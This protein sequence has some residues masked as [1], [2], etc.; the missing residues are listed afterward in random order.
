M[1]SKAAA[2][3]SATH[4]ASSSAPGEIEVDRNVIRP[5]VSVVVVTYR[6]STEIPGCVDSLLKQP[7][8]VEVF[9]VDNASPD[10][11]PEIIADY[12]SRFDNV[13]AIL[14]KENLGLAAAN[15][16]ALGRCQGDYVLILNPD[17]LV[18]D[19]T[20]QRMVN[21]LDQ[22]L[23]VGIVGPQNLYSDGT[24]H[25]SFHRRWGLLQV[26]IWR[27][28]PYRFA[29]S[30]FDVFSSYRSQDL[31]FVS[32]A[33]LLIRQ[34][35]FERIRGYDAEFFLTVEDACDLCIRARQTGSRV[36]FLPEAEVIHFGGRSGVQAPYIV[37][38]EGYRG[39][40]YYFLKHKGIAQ[41]VLV[42]LL[43]VVGAGVRSLLA[44]ILG[45]ARR[46]Y[47]RVG[48]IYGRVCWDLV[49]QNPI[50]VSKLRAGN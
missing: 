14:N 33:C 44:G 5:R 15:N 3:I 32:G 47:R 25:R 50:F 21:F 40:V 26:L 2:K 48:R 46:R 42:S 18:R 39:T 28:L 4:G 29:R 16:C 27:L 6:S 17:T 11:S 8:P 36:V 35:I 45:V 24:R 20:L 41:A 22:N 30:F 34:S 1:Q 12:A 43:L 9:L 31:L 49:T 10:S 7:V 19:D 23:D 38:W 37:V 13:H